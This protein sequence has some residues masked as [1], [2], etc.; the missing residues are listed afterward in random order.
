M[1]KVETQQRIKYLIEHGGLWEQATDRNERTHHILM[2]G[3]AINILLVL[4][5]ILVEHHHLF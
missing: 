5:D 4:W 1:D 2:V 3:V